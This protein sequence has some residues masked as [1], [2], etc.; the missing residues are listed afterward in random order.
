MAGSRCP[1][2]SC[3]PKVV[4]KVKTRNSKSVTNPYN[5]V[6]FLRMISQSQVIQISKSLNY[7]KLRICRH[8]SVSVDSCGSLVSKVS[9]RDAQDKDLLK[10]LNATESIEAAR[11]SPSLFVQLL[12]AVD[13]GQSWHAHLKQTS[14][15][16]HFQPHLIS[17]RLRISTCHHMVINLQKRRCKPDSNFTKASNCG[18]L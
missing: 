3:A 6:T 5:L 7:P 9:W 17:L 10:H 18:S 1:T 8:C 15:M 4:A 16:L 13:R 14:E 12:G 2:T 11:R